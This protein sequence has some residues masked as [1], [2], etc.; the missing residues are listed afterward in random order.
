MSNNQLTFNTKEK[1]NFASNENIK[2]Q[3]KDLVIKKSLF[4]EVHMEM[5]KKYKE[6]MEYKA[7]DFSICNYNDTQTIKIYSK[8]L[9]F[10][11]SE[12]YKMENPP[13]LKSKYNNTKYYFI[14][15]ALVNAQ[16]THEYCDDLLNK[17]NQ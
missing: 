17:K 13:F 11:T 4:N 14:S 16:K 8:N 15:R 12:K 5:K 1:K 3:E 10:W 7:D 9:F 6:F 2:D